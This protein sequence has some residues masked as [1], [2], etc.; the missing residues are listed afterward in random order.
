[1]GDN[2]LEA[3]G[4]ILDP[5]GPGI[6]DLQLPEPDEA[7]LPR[8]A[9]VGQPYSGTLQIQDGLGPFL[10]QITTGTLPPG[11]NLADTTGERQFTNTL[12]GTPTTGGLYTFTVTVTDLGLPGE[13][14]AEITL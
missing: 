10:W 13:P 6:S 11:L 5:G 14:S 1:R 12:S 2:T 7:S 8:T 4:R 3:N 9:E